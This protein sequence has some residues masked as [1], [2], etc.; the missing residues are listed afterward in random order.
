MILT[1]EVCGPEA[2]SLGA[3]G[4][5]VFDGTGG[6]IGRLPDNDW[7]LPGE[8]VSGHHARI[9][10]RSGQFLVEDTSTNGV[11]VNS[12]DNR[13]QRG[14]PYPIKS[15]DRLF[16][17]MY[18]ISVAVTAG[19]RARDP[20]V[21]A[22]IGGGSR[23]SPLIPEDPF[24]VDAFEATPAPMGGARAGRRGPP[25][26]ASDP[27]G[28]LVDPIAGTGEADPLKVLGIENKRAP[29]PRAPRASDLA[30]G[31][32]LSDPYRPPVV[33]IPEVVE[34][35]TPEP[36]IPE[37]PAPH[38]GVIPPDY[39]PL[40]PETSG[41]A[42]PAEP[43]VRSSPRQQEAPPRVVAP[44]PAVLRRPSPGPASA[45]A[46]RSAGVTPAAP[47]VP[48]RAEPAP[49]AP[50]PPVAPAPR[51]PETP[52]E[53]DSPDPMAGVVASQVPGRLHIPER[54]AGAPRLTGTAASSA[55]DFNF[56]AFLQ[57][58]G[59]Q[60]VDV[61]PQLARDFG[62]VLRVVIAGLM[63]TLRARERI[64]GEFRLRATTFKQTDN[65]PLKFSA[66]LEDALHNLLVK[67]NPA[68]LGPVEAFEDAFRDVRNHQ[69]AMLAGVRVA[70]EAMLAQF[71]PQ[72]L[73]ADFDRQLKKGGFLGAPARL[74][75]WELYRERFRD[76]VR[77]TDSCFR[78]L[79][80]DEFAKAYEEQ[81]ERLRAL[82][83]ATDK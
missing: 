13:L 52:P 65:N 64:K 73:Q 36:I 22:Q 27:L 31:S 7:V 29:A 62:E 54:A 55:G 20:F 66:N 81:L 58:A 41:V 83:R 77:D 49:P 24:A 12:P 1:L 46:P 14:R 56:A 69:M 67:R 23:N 34:P 50:I 82:P 26:D 71:D 39:D 40:A 47:R 37:D 30:S 35:L 4:R 78:D 61:S 68:Y 45:R 19:E 76:R 2:S 9:Q 43:P 38:Q 18:E 15:G 59:V 28:D 10:F 32:P 33:R 70:Y 75:Y 51:G 17:D 53:P 74:K 6:L 16:I 21:P 60:G 80:G 42:S 57:G 8:Y 63:E 3:A 44:P 11:A 72:R 79:F 48:V 5:K 25:G